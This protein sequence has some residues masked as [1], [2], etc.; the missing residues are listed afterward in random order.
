MDAG[1]LCPARMVRT[2]SLPSLLGEAI[3]TRK[4]TF[5]QPVSSKTT[6]SQITAFLLFLLRFLVLTMINASAKLVLMVQTAAE[7][8]R[9]LESAY[10]K[11]H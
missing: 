4:E 8:L 11:Y 3:N 1:P 9:K 6:C 2:L 5:L 7:A 10:T